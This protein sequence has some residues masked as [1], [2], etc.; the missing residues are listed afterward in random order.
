MNEPQISY[1]SVAASIN[2]FVIF[3]MKHILKRIDFQ[4]PDNYEDGINATEESQMTTL[5]GGRFLTMTN[6]Y[7]DLQRTSLIPTQL[8]IQCQ[9]KE[10]ENI[11][12]NAK[13]ENPTHC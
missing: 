13:Q 6:N 1:I 9:S 12:A 3:S 5:V 11:T 8:S 7:L 4:A 2:V 10:Y